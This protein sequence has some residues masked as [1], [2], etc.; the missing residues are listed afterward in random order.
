MEKSHFPEN[1]SFKKNVQMVRASYEFI[2]NILNNFSLYEFVNRIS[3]N[4][5]IKKQQKRLN[6]GSCAFVDREIKFSFDLSP[7]NL[8][9]KLLILYME[10][11]FDENKMQEFIISLECLNQLAPY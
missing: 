8:Y 3:Q 5:Y 7:Y 4:I 10:E 6:L 1:I 2:K 9:M 11:K